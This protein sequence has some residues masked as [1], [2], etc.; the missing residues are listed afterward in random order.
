MERLMKNNFEEWN[1]KL[2]KNKNNL[3]YSTAWNENNYVKGI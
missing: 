1:K 2:L 3:N